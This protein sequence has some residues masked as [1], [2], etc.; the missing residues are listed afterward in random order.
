LGLAVAAL[1]YRYQATRYPV[2][3]LDTPVAMPGAHLVVLSAQG[4]HTKA[5]IKDAL[6][7]GKEYSPVFLY[8]APPTNLPPPHIFEIRDRFGMDEEAQL[9]LSRAKRACTAAGVTCQYLYAVGGAEQVFDVARRVRPTEIVA[10]EQTARRITHSPFAEGG[11]AVS[12]EHVRYR[13]ENGTSVAH[14]VLHDIYALGAH[15]LH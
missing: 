8:L 14:Y 12:P 13:R 3:F 7:Q 11:F 9:A 1:H 10:E 15:D 2:V 5:V 4:N 6:R